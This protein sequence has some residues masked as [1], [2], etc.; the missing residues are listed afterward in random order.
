MRQ[1]SYTGP[2]QLRSRL[3]SLSITDLVA[4]KAAMRPRVS[5]DP[6]V[7]ATKVALAALGRR[8]LSL[9]DELVGIDEF[10]TKQVTASAPEMLELFGVGTDTT[11]TLLVTAGDNPERL[12]SEATWAHLCGV[13][14]IEAS[15]GKVT[16]HRLD[17]GGDRNANQALW[18]IVMTRLSFDPRTREYMER[19]TKEGRSKR[20]IIRILKRY[21]ARE[22]F[23]YLP[24][25]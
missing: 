9:E 19:R 1:L 22:V 18:R 25:P 8:V 21:V 7:Y 3:K 20:E 23:K 14:P 2:D 6:V 16:R 15:S 10:L 11:A 12:R 13:A 17:R 4:E 24:R 5:G